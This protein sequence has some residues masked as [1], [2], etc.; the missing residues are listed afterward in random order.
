M[1]SKTGT[2]TLSYIQKILCSPYN[3]NCPHSHAFRKYLVVH[4]IEIQFA[5]QNYIKNYIMQFQILL[6]LLFFFYIPNPIFWKVIF[7]SDFNEKL[8]L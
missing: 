8:I 5:K 3:R 4:I 1:H 6:L 2:T 7:L